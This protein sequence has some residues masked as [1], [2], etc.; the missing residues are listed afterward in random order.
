R[1]YDKL[2]MK[3][4]PLKTEGSRDFKNNLN[5]QSLTIVN[6]CKLEPSLKTA[7]AGNIYQFERLGYFCVDCDSNDKKIIFNRTA[8]LKDEWVK[9]KASIKK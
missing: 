4:N 1:L 7:K 8:R 6:D 2:F 3:E 9:I 5:P